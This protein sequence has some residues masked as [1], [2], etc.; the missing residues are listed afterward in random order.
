MLKISSLYIGADHGGF[1]L[2]TRLKPWLIETYGA[3]IQDMGALSPDPLDDYP[4]FVLPVAQALSVADEPVSQDPTVWGILSCRS[5]LGATMVANRFRGVRAAVCS[6][7]QQASLAR[8]HNNANVLVLEGDSIDVMEAQSLVKL[9]LSTPFEGGRHIRR[10]E[11]FAELGEQA[12]NQF[13][14]RTQP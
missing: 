1:E 2:K 11:M 6:S 10:L 12:E 7:A 8:A 5:G 3:Q 13:S 9:F 14:A 4:Q